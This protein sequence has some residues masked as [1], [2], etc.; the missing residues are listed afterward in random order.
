MSTSIFNPLLLLTCWCVGAVIGSCEYI[1]K[2]MDFARVTLQDALKVVPEYCS[3]PHTHV[4]RI[5]L[6]E[7]METSLEI[8]CVFFSNFQ[9]ETISD[10]KYDDIGCPIT[11]RSEREIMSLIRDLYNVVR[12]LSDSHQRYLGPL[13]ME[14][15]GLAMFGLSLHSPSLLLDEQLMEHVEPDEAKRNHKHRRIHLVSYA[16]GDMQQALFR[17]K[18]R[19]FISD[20]EATYNTSTEAVKRNALHIFEKIPL[21]ID[22]PAASDI[23]MEPLIKKLTTHIRAQIKRVASHR[24]LDSRTADTSIWLLQNLR[25]LM[26]KLL[27]YNVDDFAVTDYNFKLASS[28]AEVYRQIY[29]DNGV[30]FLCL[31]LISVGIHQELAIEAMKMLVALLLKSGGAEA[32]QQNIYMYLKETDSVLFIE[33]IKETTEALQLWLQREIDSWDVSEE[34]VV[35]PHMILFKMLQL[36]CEG[37]SVALKD[38]LRLQ[39]DNSRT[40]KLSDCFVNFLDLTSRNESALSTYVAVRILKAIQKL[41]QGPCKGNQEEYILNT[42]LV[43]CINRL[44]RLSTP[45]FDR[46]MGQ[47]GM[48][49]EKLKN[50]VIAVLRAALEGQTQTSVVFERVTTTTEFSV[51]NTIFLSVQAE[52]SL[53]EELLELGNN[54]LVSDDVVEA[55]SSKAVNPN[56]LVFLKTLNQLEDLEGVPALHKSIGEIACVEIVWQNDVHRTYFHIPEIVKELSERSKQ[57]IVSDAETVSQEM[58]LKD[59]TLRAHVLY[60]EIEHQLFLANY[61]ISNLWQ[62]ESFLAWIMFCNACV[63]NALILAYLG[64]ADDNGF[65]NAT[66]TYTHTTDSNATFAAIVR[67]M[68]TTADTVGTNEGSGKLGAGAGI[69]NSALLVYMDPTATGALTGLNILQII[70][71]VVTLLIFV[72]GKMPVTYVTHIEKNDKD[73]LQ[74]VLSTVADPLPLWYSV[75]LLLAILGLCFDPLWLS[76]LLLDWVVLDSTS[77]DVL[78]AVQYPARQLFAT[79]IIILIILNIFSGVV[80]VLYRQQVTDFDI[81]DMW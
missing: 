35:H 79:L 78:L 33:Y 44:M 74:A 41:L 61:G 40:V 69:S 4:L 58:K 25:L 62:I 55:I 17:N 18:Y 23:R 47:W 1:W 27:G 48:E 66:G 7:W 71:A 5:Q 13:L 43:V 51:F 80:F 49:S 28:R 26:E 36:I 76:G 6:A 53:E 21:R 64:T 2:F 38:L 52:D 68:L 67:R 60:R 24:S 70:L 3:R 32:V 22:G 20:V 72:I 56:Y 59:F 29:N 37:E 9:L 75:Y 14:M 31:D 77:R 10:Q 42:E 73:V 19:R 11:N 39:T 63:M 46:H 65:Y 30:T 81:Y 50:T 57:Q 34:Q 54:L 45:I 16:M 8:M 12:N 15:L